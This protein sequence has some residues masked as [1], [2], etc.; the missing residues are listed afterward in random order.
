MTITNDAANVNASIGEDRAERLLETLGKL[1][2]WL[3][4]ENVPAQTDMTD[5][6]EV[7][8]TVALQSVSNYVQSVENTEAVA[9]VIDGN[10]REQRDPD[11]QASFDARL[12]DIA[13]SGLPLQFDLV[14]NG[15]IGVEDGPSD[16]LPDG[17][18]VAIITL[19]N[20]EFVALLSDQLG[21]RDLLLVAQE[22][23]IDVLIR[24]AESA[25]LNVLDA[26]VPDALATLIRD[27]ELSDPNIGG[28]TT[29]WAQDQQI[30]S[31]MFDGEITDASIR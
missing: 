25:G 18:D 26:S 19:D 12:R 5:D 1:D 30:I 24:E 27:G 4:I 23:A 31:V 20:A 11:V 16:M 10:F 17:V 2:D 6:L 8:A 22:A 7:V 15:E 14:P 13:Y 9:H 21:F 29:A 3:V 28:E